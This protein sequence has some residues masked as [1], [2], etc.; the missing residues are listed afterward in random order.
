MPDLN[1]HIEG[2]QAVPFAAAPL[3]GFQ[4]QVANAGS[5]FVHTVALRCQIQIEPAR[6]RYSVESQ[7]GLEDLFGE[8]HRWGQT[9][10][11]MLWTHAS[12]VV[13]AFAANTVFELQVPCTFDFN[14]AAVKY[15]R[16]L[17]DG[18]IPLRFQFSGTVFYEGAGGNMQV[19]PISWSKEATFRLPVKAWN[20][21]MDLYYPNSAWLCLRRDVFEKLYRHKVRQGV[22]TWEEM[23]EGL[24]ECA[25]EKVAQ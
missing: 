25:A 12:A 6:R 1:F 19:A 17:A 7:A 2:A 3:L 8:P 20:G 9:L 22:P 16:G 10:R 18:E 14:I 23:L 11:N 24:L 4:I 15:F 13:P 21:M 5:E